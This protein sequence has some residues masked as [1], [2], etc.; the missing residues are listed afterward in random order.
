[1]NT[2]P[3]FLARMTGIFW[4]LT[5]L[6]GFAT[7]AVG[8]TAGRYVNDAAAFTYLIASIYASGL[9]KP[10][11]RNL[12]ILTG[13][14]GTIGSLISLDHAFLHLL[15]G[16]R[17]TPF[18][19]FGLQLLLLGYLIIRS[20]YIPAWVGGLLVIGGLGWLT[21]GLSSLLSPEFARMLV[22]YILLPGVVGETSLTLRLLTRGVD[23]NR[24]QERI[25]HPNN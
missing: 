17:N 24:W 20:G 9:L 22:P 21:L 12:A 15:P 8:G 18:V 13:F 5:I 2:D 1:M 3:R 6:A 25:S 4:A 10:V 11:D 19:F 16:P 7:L 14:L 23:V